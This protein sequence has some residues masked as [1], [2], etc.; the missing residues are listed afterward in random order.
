[1]AGIAPEELEGLTASEIREKVSKKVKKVGTKVGKGGAVGGMALLGLS[2]YG[3]D[4]AGAA[5]QDLA[6]AGTSKVIGLAGGPGVTAGMVAA[7]SVAPTVVA[8]DVQNLV[9][10]KNFM[11]MGRISDITGESPL[12]INTR[13]QA[14]T[15]IQ[16][17]E[18][19]A[20][21]AKEGGS[22]E[23][24]Q[25]TREKQA[26]EARLQEQLSEIGF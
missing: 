14:L 10:D 12:D 9:S 5:A 16:D 19:Q 18:A 15:D 8:D 17:I 6:Y 22:F 4:P 13:A 24:P 20:S 21:G 3:T 1:M 26:N 11:E 23:H 25:I 2:A 7:E